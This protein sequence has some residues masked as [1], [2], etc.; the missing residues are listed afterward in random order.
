MP[1]VRA[2]VFDFPVLE[3]DDLV[4]DVEIPI[5]VG[6]GDDGPSLGLQRG[7]QLLIEKPAKRRVLI[8]GE[9]VEHQD[10]PVLEQADDERQ[11][12]ALP[13]RQ[14]EIRK[15]VVRELHLVIELH[16]PQQ[17]GDGGFVGAEQAVEPPEQD[18][19]SL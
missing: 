7:Q 1:L 10:R 14:L 6:R 4:G 18:S 19:R 5:V 16:L 9:L 17:R 3:L 8:G 13:A 12:L 15:P 2:H 11:P